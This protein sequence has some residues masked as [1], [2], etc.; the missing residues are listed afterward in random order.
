MPYQGRPWRLK[1]GNWK[2]PWIKEDEAE[3]VHREPGVCGADEFVTF[4]EDNLRAE[5]ESSEVKDSWH[6]IQVLLG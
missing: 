4:P 1:A 3:V 5:H 6:F 2:E